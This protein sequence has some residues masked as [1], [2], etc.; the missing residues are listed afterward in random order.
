MTQTDPPRNSLENK[1]NMADMRM[2]IFMKKVA[3]L[4]KIRNEGIGKPFLIRE[5]AEKRRKGIPMSYG[6]DLRK[7]ENCAGRRAMRFVA[8]KMRKRRSG[9]IP[10][11]IWK[12]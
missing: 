5:V 1:L 4:D 6:R 7:D 9:K 3:R 12:K 10:Q 8:R 2:L 11:D